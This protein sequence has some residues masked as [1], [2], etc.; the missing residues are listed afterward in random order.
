VLQ[1]SLVHVHTLAG[2]AAG[3]GTAF[4][5][6]VGLT[7]AAIA[8]AIILLRAERAARAA[9]GADAGASPEA[10]AEAMAA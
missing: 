7:A 4:W 6:S 2:A 3:Y 1:R 10:L 9:R 8:P 5:W